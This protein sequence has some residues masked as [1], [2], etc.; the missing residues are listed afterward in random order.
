MADLRNIITNPFINRFGTDIMAITGIE[1]SSPATLEEYNVFNRLFIIDFSKTNVIV[2]TFCSSVAQTLL[3]RFAHASQ[4]ENE[5]N[6]IVISLPVTQTSTLST[7][8]SII[9]R[10]FE[11]SYTRG[12]LLKIT[13]NTSEVYYGTK[14]IILDKDFNI[15]ILCAFSYNIDFI[16]KKLECSGIYVYINPKIFANNDKLSKI[17]VSK[18]I[19]SFVEQGIYITLNSDQ[20]DIYPNNLIKPIIIIDENINRFISHPEEPNLGEDINEDLNNIL[21]NNIDDVLKI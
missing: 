14:G 19:P 1:E 7:P 16:N 2:P 3:S 11:R 8:I 18:V 15:L 4:N 6:K 21:R 5:I 17:I 12:E 9:R 13:T 10:F 20:V